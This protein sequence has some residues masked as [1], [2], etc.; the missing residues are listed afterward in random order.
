MSATWATDYICYFV[1]EPDNSD[2]EGMEEGYYFRTEDE[3][4]EGPYLTQEVAERSLQDY[5][6]YQVQ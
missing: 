6:K 3:R 4:L 1:P 2:H 5:F